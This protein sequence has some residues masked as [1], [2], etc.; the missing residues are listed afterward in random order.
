VTRNLLSEGVATRY[1][2]GNFF[3]PVFDSQFADVRGGDFRLIDSS[4]FRSAGTDG[5]DLGVD[6]TRLKPAFAAADGSPVA[7]T[8]PAAPSGL[9]QVTGGTK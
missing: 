5:A 2:A 8:P 9:R 4:P 6:L 3:S 1:P 7:G